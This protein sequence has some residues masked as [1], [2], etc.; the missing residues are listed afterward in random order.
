[1]RK[2]QPPVVSCDE[3]GGFEDAGVSGARGVMIKGCHPPSKVVVFYDNHVGTLSP[4]AIR[5]PGEVVFEG[6]A[7]ER[8]MMS[9]LSVKAGLLDVS[10]A[11][12]I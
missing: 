9:S 3:L 5:S 1:M 4:I 10:A 12:G 8:S 11:D 2:L 6:P 7:F